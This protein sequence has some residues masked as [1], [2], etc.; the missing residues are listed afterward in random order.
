MTLSRLINA[1]KS[2][3][4][5]NINWPFS[6]MLL[7]LILTDFSIIMDIPILRQVLGFTFFSIVPGMIILIGI[8]EIKNIGITDKVVLSIG[9]SIS[10]LIF[11]GLLINYIYPLF[12]YDTP[13]S[14]TSL[15]ISLSIILLALGITAYFKNRTSQF[16]E[17]PHLRLSFRE[18][19]FLLLPAFFPLLSIIGMHQMNTTDNNAILMA[20]LFLIPAYFI[21]IALVHINVPERDYASI[22]FL[23]SISLVLLLGLRSNHIIGADSH[24]EYYVFQQTI[25]NGQ[26]QIIFNN[27][28]DSCL[29]ISILPTVY[30]SLTG[31]DPEFLFKILYPIIFSTSPLVIYI[32]SRK[33]IGSFYAFLGSLY[34]MSQN[35][36]LLTTASPRTNVAILFFSLSIM[37]LFHKEMN[38]FYKK[39][40]FIIFAI[41]CIVSHYATTY[42]FFFILFFSWLSMQVFHRALSSQIKS[43]KS[44]ILLPNSLESQVTPKYPRPLQ[45]PDITIGIVLLFFVVLFLWQ[46]QITG[47]AFNSGVSFIL[48]SFESLQYFF[49]QET[50]STG[51]AEAFGSGLGDKGIPQKINF[52]FSWMAIILIAIG[53]L[54]TLTRYRQRV[55][56][57]DWDEE[58]HS[59]FLSQRLDAEFFAS[60]LICSCILTASIALPFV[61][62]GYGME[63]A[64]CQMIVVLL[65]YIV[66]GGISV[67][68]YFNISCK[69]LFIM[70]AIIPFFM[71]HTGTMYQIFGYPSEM[72]LNSEGQTYDVLFVHDQESFGARWLKNFGQEDIKIFA[73][74]ASDS[75]LLSQAGILL[76]SYP[77]ELIEKGK[78]LGEG[79]FYMRY[80]GVVN[81]KLM[82]RKYRWH[83]VTDYKDEF[84][85]RELIYVNG[86][87]E[88]WK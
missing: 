54:T 39:L 34:F 37:V 55:A 74:Y 47:V 75:R 77:K 71:C 83:N 29:S 9:L 35:T 79:Y 38:D 65:P 69:Y 4:S 40:L 1:L 36:F 68:E 85:K 19:A 8:L 15:V 61:F 12:G 56:L 73:D 27:T 49:I 3:T 20:L 23:T 48:S 31:I 84:A 59:S 24:S 45:K 63:R 66:I 5:L 33:Y 53:V 2:W 82:D 11:A 44:N 17:L 80:C 50:R 58:P 41:S 25:Y 81:G 67:A 64:Y 76:S 51:V 88:I 46:S 7:S 42:I 22:I 26:W 78:R 62:V 32:I 57:L 6:L 14:T 87:S 52:V 43:P 13:L 86:G 72:T 16:I 28:L 21:I 30:Q 18:K 70:V 60:S 10:F